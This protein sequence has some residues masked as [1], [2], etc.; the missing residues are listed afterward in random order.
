MPLH[1]RAVVLILTLM[2]SGLALASSGQD[3]VPGEFIVKLKGKSSSSQNNK[4]M[5]KAQSKMGLKA[6]FHRMNIH[7]FKIKPGEDFNQ[8]MA[9]LRDDPDVE[10]VE[11]NWIVRRF[12]DSANDNRILSHSE[13]QSYFSVSSQS[14]QA[15][16]Q[17][18]APINME[19][20]WQSSVSLADQPERPIVAVIDSG[21]D[22]NHSVFV[23]T[24]AI[25][26]NPLEIAGNGVDDDGNGYVDDVRGWNFASRNNNPMDDDGH[27]THVAGIVLGASQDITASSLEPAK[28]RIM[29]LK[30]LGADGS[31]TTSSAISAI[32]YAV[33]NGAQVINNSWGGSSYSQALHDA[34]TYAYDNKVLVVSAAGNYTNNNDVMSMYPAN[35]PVP[36]NLAVAASSDSDNLAS[37]TNYGANTVHIAAP[38]V[39]ILST[40][41]GDSFRFMSGTSMAAPLAAGIAAMMLREAPALT[42]YQVKNLLLD[43]ADYIS[44][45]S[46]KI[47]SASRVN[48][49][50]AIWSAKGEINSAASQPAYLASGA[51]SPASSDSVGGCGTIA[52]VMAQ[53][54]FENIGRGGGVSGGGFAIV[55]LSLPLLIWL[56]LRRKDAKNRRRH[57]RFLMDSGIKVRMGERELVG[58]MKT[59]SVGGLSF[60]ADELLDRGG[61]VSIQISSPDGTEQFQVQGHIVWSEENKAYGVQFDEQRSYVKEAIK[62]WTGKLSKAN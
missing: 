29:A 9:E 30:F 34:L 42:G 13:V 46:G 37:F 56:V 39:V 16:Y 11:P 23:D 28:V 51:R 54:S 62:Q 10:Y 24:G 25:W 59:I 12:N 58:Q 15:Y 44:A 35:Y 14:T 27:G 47:T 61:T 55:L 8:V 57:D 38:G 18:G 41:T 40:Y 3:Y 31:G 22:Y 21:V 5:S 48:A 32:Y 33:N 19:E 60:T 6:S 20:A 1:W 52:S 7:K 43:S 4:F 45:F 2:T 36:S 26:T 53:Q 49:E 50:G 17:S